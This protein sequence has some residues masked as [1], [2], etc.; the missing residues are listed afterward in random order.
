MTVGQELVTAGKLRLGQA[1]AGQAIKQ[2]QCA[3]QAQRLRVLTD[4]RTA[5][6]DSLAAQQMVALYGQLVDIGQEGLQTTEKLLAGKEASRVDVLQARVE[7]RSVALQLQ[8]ARSQQ[9]GTWRRLAS[10]VGKPDMPLTPLAGN[11]EEQLPPLTWQEARSRLFAGSPELAE[12][13]AGVQRAQCALQQQLAQRVPNLQVQ[14]G[15]AYDNSTG[16]NTASASIGVPLPIFNRNQGNITRA[17]AEL[18]DARR[19]VERLQLQLQQRLATAFQQFESA[20]QQAE[21]YRGEILPDAGQSLKLTRE[22]YRAGE[23]NYLTLLTAQRTYFQVSLSYVQ[24]LQSLHVSRAAI[25][26]MLLSGGLGPG[27]G[28][29]AGPAVTAAAATPMV[30]AGG[31]AASAAGE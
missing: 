11:L 5:F 1:V 26:G 4:V 30:P 31:A 18:T 8:N 21:K 7:A 6:Y 17:E 19:D 15:M 12:A 20:W 2:A 16:Y 24:S 3:F 22:G 25:E 23:L 10:V 13:Q 14:A 27:A 29:T 9:A 28:P